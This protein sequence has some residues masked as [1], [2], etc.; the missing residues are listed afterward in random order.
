[1][2]FRLS[3]LCL[4]VLYIGPVTT[5]WIETDESPKKRRATT[6]QPPNFQVTNVTLAPKDDNSFPTFRYQ[7]ALKAMKW[8]E[9]R[10]LKNFITEEKIRLKESL[11]EEENFDYYPA[12]L[13]KRM[14]TSDRTVV[15]KRR[16]LN[17][18]R[19]C[20]N[21]Q[22]T[23]LTECSSSLD[24]DMFCVDSNITQGFGYTC[25]ADYSRQ[26][27]WAYCN[28]RWNPIRVMTIYVP[29]QCSVYKYCCPKD[30]QK[31]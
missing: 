15:E 2:K 11:R 16:V 10:T 17:S 6:C 21:I 22:P 7:T 28:A 30:G 27:L 13:Y 31:S 19:N 20:W 14:C 23:I 4:L 18:A 25:L 1:M 12:C 26:L 29:F 9:R 24:A 3:K 5:F 8:R